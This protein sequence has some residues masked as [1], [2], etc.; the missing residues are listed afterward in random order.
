MPPKNKKLEDFTYALIWFI[1]TKERYVVET[2]KLPKT[3]RK[4]G[5]VIKILWED[6]STQISTRYEVK[7]LEFD[8]DKTKLSNILLDEDGN[9][10]DEN[11][12]V[13]FRS[14]LDKKRLLQ[15]GAKL[16]VAKNKIQKTSLAHVIAKKKPLFEHTGSIINNQKASGSQT[17]DFQQQFIESATIECNDT[18]SDNSSPIKIVHQMNTPGTAND[19]NETNEENIQS[20]E[21][22]D[23]NEVDIGALHTFLPVTASEENKK[24][25]KQ[26]YTGL[27]EAYERQQIDLDKKIKIFKV[28]GH[29]K[30]EI[31]PKCGIFLPVNMIETIEKKAST[32]TDVTDWKILV[33]L[34]LTEMYGDGLGDFCAIGRSKISSR[35][36]IDPDIYKGI[37]EWILLKST[38]KITNHDYTNEINRIIGNKRSS[39]LS[40]YN[41]K[42]TIS[43]SNL[44]FLKQVI[45]AVERENKW[46]EDSD[47]RFNLINLKSGDDFLIPGPTKARISETHNIFFPK[48]TIAFIEKRTESS[49]SSNLSDWRN[50][51]KEALIEVYGKNI[52]NYCAKG[53]RVSRLPIHPQ[54]YQAILAWANSR[55]EQQIDEADYVGHINK[56]A[57]NKRKTNKSKSTSKTCSKLND[58]QK[59]KPKKAVSEYS[60]TAEIQ[61]SPVKLNPPLSKP[62]QY[63][64][65]HIALVNSNSRTAD[66]RNELSLEPGITSESEFQQHTL[67]NIIHPMNLATK[68][69]NNQNPVIPDA[70]NVDE[71]KSN[72][73]DPQVI[74]PAEPDYIPAC[75]YSVNRHSWTTQD[76]YPWATQS[77]I[78]SSYQY[79]NWYCSDQHSG[80]YTT[81]HYNYYPPVQNF[82]ENNK[83]FMQRDPKDCEYQYHNQSTS[84]ITDSGNS[85]FTIL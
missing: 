65:P 84:L 28:D 70:K 51:V 76:Q 49:K 63:L 85:N 50:L 66:Y 15:E 58:Q 24:F 56:I 17:N 13:F 10:C 22:S 2:N 26:I 57:S 20:L 78:D 61:N 80:L 14:V 36:S 30:K 5:N 18:S 32:E 74:L 64:E 12:K 53:T 72:L 47:D 1:R 11:A 9:V 31:S 54:L 71:Q 34:A 42:D 37:F 19:L 83:V 39:K 21:L 27:S 81:Q 52:H 48:S 55:S 68:I 79:P 16:D 38:E 62:L 75:D 69:V 40:S 82:N 35:P 59:V 29:N 7:I 44:Y 6:P 45:T 23:E 46:L 3:R 73:F 41:S 4:K 25:L 8:N 77:S 60:S 33:K 67:P 43:Q